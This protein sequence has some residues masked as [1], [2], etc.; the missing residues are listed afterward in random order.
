MKG[1]KII[2]S[3]A[4]LDFI[5]SN[6][7]M[8]IKRLHESFCAKFNRT[9]VSSSN[10]HSLRKR[11]GWKTGRDGKFTK[12]QRKIPNSGC[13]KANKTS[14]KKG[15]KPHNWK[16]V[17][18]TRVTRDGYIE[19]KTEEPKKWRLEHLFLWE[20]ENGNLPKGYCL[21][22]ID[23]NKLN[24]SLPNLELITRNDNLQ[25][26]IVERS[27]GKEFRDTTRLIGKI[28]SAANKL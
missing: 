21:S 11:K 22:F 3:Q 14:F 18:S 4:E 25:I 23:G 8:T 9:N 6:R 19:V 15:A 17:G 26:N 10:L 13:K 16:P 24:T 5:S 20:K 7:T 12:G 28:K 27:V 1:V 2:Y